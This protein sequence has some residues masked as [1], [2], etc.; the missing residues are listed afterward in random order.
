MY[1]LTEKVIVDAL[2]PENEGPEEDSGF[3]ECH[4]GHEM[5]AFI[6][7]FFEEGVNPASVPF[8]KKIRSTGRQGNLTREKLTIRRKLCK[9]RM[10][11]ATMPGI[12]AIVSKNKIRY[13]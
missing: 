2:G 5:H 9:W 8:L 6:L 11:A 13:R 7:G 4:E 3:T 10:V 1:L 12:P